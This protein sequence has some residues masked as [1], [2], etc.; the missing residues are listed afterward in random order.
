MN[1]R[2]NG[3]NGMQMGQEQQQQSVSWHH[4]HSNHHGYFL[5]NLKFYY[6]NDNILVLPSEFLICFECTKI[7]F[8][9]SL[10][11]H[12]IPTELQSWI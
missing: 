11:S 8:F 4:Q 7:Y 2:L 1:T 10:F 5:R 9:L 3:N 12:E 6:I